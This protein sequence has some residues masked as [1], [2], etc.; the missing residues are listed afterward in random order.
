MKAKGIRGL[1][2]YFC[3]FFSVHCDLHYCIF[4]WSFLLSICLVV[5]FNYIIMLGL[6]LQQWYNDLTGNSA[7][8][9]GYPDELTPD[10]H[11]TVLDGNTHKITFFCPFFEYL[12][13]ICDAS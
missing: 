12:V 3:I 2:L 9:T 13:Q 6:H 4:L 8:T 5:L 7:P 11:I 10:I 1:M